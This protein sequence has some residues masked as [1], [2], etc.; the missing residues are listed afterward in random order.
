M[1]GACRWGE[2]AALEQNVS[3]EGREQQPEVVKEGGGWGWVHIDRKNKVERC[4]A[5]GLEMGL[6]W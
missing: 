3:A 2:G 5:P 4:V 1:G 6:S